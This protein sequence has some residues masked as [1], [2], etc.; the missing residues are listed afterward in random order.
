MFV[1]PCLCQRIPLTA[2]TKWFSF[3]LKLLREIYNYFGVRYLK[4]PKRNQQ[5]LHQ[6]K[7]FKCDV[8]NA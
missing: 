1:Y 5:K 8:Q 3:T 7:N 2:V 4:P 6:Q